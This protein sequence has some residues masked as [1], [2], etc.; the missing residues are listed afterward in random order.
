MRTATSRLPVARL[1]HRASSGPYRFL[2]LSDTI[3][4]SP[5]IQ[6][7]GTSG[8]GPGACPAC[9]AAVSD[10]DTCEGNTV[11]VL[12]DGLNFYPAELEAMRG[13]ER[14]I[15]LE[16]YIF[17]A[18]EVVDQFIKVMSERASAGVRVNLLSTRWVRMEWRCGEA[19]FAGS[20]QRAVMCISIIR[21]RHE[22]STES[23]SAHTVKLLS[24]MA[25]QP[26]SE[27]RES[28]TTGCCRA[29]AAPGAT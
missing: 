17:W 18:G 9:G 19:V 1:C 2:P 12:T 8:S 11:E 14:S 13:A 27:V 23:T 28:Q 16:V 24:S 10:A 29:A 25:G 26:L 7:G 4:S 6:R 21:S 20:G 5:C 22:C 3:R 15:N